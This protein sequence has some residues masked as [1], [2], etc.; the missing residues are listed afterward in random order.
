M[1]N[2]TV[3]YMSPISS[4]LCC[5]EIRHTSIVTP[6]TTIA[7]S[8]R[9]VLRSSDLAGLGVDVAV[10]LWRRAAEDARVEICALCLGGC[11]GSFGDGG[12]RSGCWSGDV[13]RG[14]R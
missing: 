2:R 10:E 13:L 4:C 12:G 9:L 6:V 5:S 1:V 3:L 14:C 8:Q 7:P 11:C